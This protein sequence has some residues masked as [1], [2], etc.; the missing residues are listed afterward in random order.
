[1]AEQKASEQ[2]LEDELRALGQAEA[3]RRD[4]EQKKLANDLIV[5]TSKNSKAN[6]DEEEREDGERDK[7]EEPQ[8]DYPMGQN[9]DD[10]DDALDRNVPGPTTTTTTEGSLG[11]LGF[12]V[13]QTPPPGPDTRPPCLPTPPGHVCASWAELND[14]VE[15]IL[16]RDGKSWY[17][18]FVTVGHTSHT[19]SFSIAVVNASVTLPLAVPGG[20]GPG[21]PS[22]DRYKGDG[23]DKQPAI[24]WDKPISVVRL[25]FV[26]KTFCILQ[27]GSQMTCHATLLV[28]RKPNDALR[29]LFDNHFWQK[30]I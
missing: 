23:G 21:G 22:V 4:T 18:W 17:C 11:S 29:F 14:K 27:D 15:A 26:A 3:S 2:K 30:A 1:L 8:E 13:P 7:G 28:E 24:S 16:Y 6:E 25:N 19:V 20:G 12:L 9:D 10:S 5:K